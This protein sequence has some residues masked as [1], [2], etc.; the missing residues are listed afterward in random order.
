MRDWCA[1]ARAPRH[2]A[3][4]VWKR[5]PGVQ[6]VPVGATI[7]P[8]PEGWQLQGLAGKLRW[9]GLSKLPCGGDAVRNGPLNQTLRGAS[10]ERQ[11]LE[12]WD[13]DD[14]CY[15]T[16]CLLG[17]LWVGLCFEGVRCQG[18]GRWVPL[19]AGGGMAGD[20][21]TPSITSTSLAWVWQ[22][23]KPEKVSVMCKMLFVCQTL[24]SWLGWF[25][26]CWDPLSAHRVQQGK[27]CKF[28]GVWNWDWSY[29]T[30]ATHL[31]LRPACELVQVSPS[32]EAPSYFSGYES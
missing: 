12:I 14:S 9:D 23:E 32:L 26:A 31:I 22:W 13:F 5:A 6:P 20:D 24:L 21:P 16:D 4:R 18:E 17:L 8:L 10:M 28:S 19:I 2:E 30:A 25:R 3:M 7:P 29:R 11:A 1:A 27:G 15:L